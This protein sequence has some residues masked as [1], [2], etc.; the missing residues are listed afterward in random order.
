M[1]SATSYSPANISCIFG[2]HKDENP[3]K[4]GSIGI[5]FCINEGVRIGFGEVTAKLLPSRK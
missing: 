3:S 4:M 2:I 5:G 1:T